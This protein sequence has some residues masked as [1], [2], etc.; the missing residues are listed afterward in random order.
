[1]NLLNHISLF[2][3]LI[4]LAMSLFQWN[5]LPSGWA[6]L[7]WLLVASLLADCLSYLTGWLFRNSFP[8]INLFFLI[9]FTVIAYIFSN[10]YNAKKVVSIVY[11]VYFLYFVINILFFESP[12]RMLTNTSMLAMLLLIVLLLYYLY[13]LMIDPVVIHI[14]REPV[15]WIAFAFLFYKSG[16]LF[17]FL[18]YN[19]AI[20]LRAIN[21]ITWN[22]WNIH[23]L[24]NILKNILIAIALWLNYRTTKSSISS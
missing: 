21:K 17:V 16:S 12:L 7:R 23:N 18:T 9:E 1:M 6:I 2:S 8:V 3:V 20:N 14:E 10:F 11:A 15:F 13:N 22:I 24:C 4:P 19:Q 5:K